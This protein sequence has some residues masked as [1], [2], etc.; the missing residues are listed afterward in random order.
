M[1]R[2][3]WLALTLTGVVVGVL[4]LIDR[5]NWR[6]GSL[7]LLAEQQARLQGLQDLV[8]G[9]SGDSNNP[10]GAYYLVGNIP[11]GYPLPSMLPQA[12]AQ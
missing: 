11:F 3:E 1:T 4:I 12:T 5:Q 7:P 8:V 9:E 2:G 6:T 10:Q